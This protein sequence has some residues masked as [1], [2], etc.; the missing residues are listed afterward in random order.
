MKNV[1]LPNEFFILAGNKVDLLVP[2]EKLINVT[3]EETSLVITDRQAVLEADCAQPDTRRFQGVQTECFTWNKLLLE[4][5]HKDR[6]VR[7]RYTADS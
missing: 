6:Y 5:N 2:I 3:C 1:I 7:W 4:V